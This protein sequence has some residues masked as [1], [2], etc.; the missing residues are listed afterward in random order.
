M[1]DKLE[2][3]GDKKVSC[4]CG[5]SGVYPQLVYTYPIEPIGPYCPRCLKLWE[6]ANE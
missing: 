5:W 2:Y 6:K 1:T 3:V 4:K